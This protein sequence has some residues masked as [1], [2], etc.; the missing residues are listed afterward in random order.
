MTSAVFPGRYTSLES[1]SEFVIQAAQHAGLDDAAVYAVQLAVDEEATNII[2]HGYGGEDLGEIGCQC[3]IVAEGLRIRLEDH[4]PPFDPQAV[5]QPVLNVP[6]EDVRPR[7]LGLFFIHKMMDE[8]QFDFS[9]EGN[10]LTMLK[11]R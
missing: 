2:E 11:R 1:I 5:A 10:T 8:V 9:P 7:G 6:L 3:E 4:A